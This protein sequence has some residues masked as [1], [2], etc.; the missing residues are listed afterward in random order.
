MDAVSKVSFME[1]Q[2]IWRLTTSGMLRLVD[3]QIFTDVSKERSANQ[4]ALLDQEAE[5]MRQLVYVMET[6][7][8]SCA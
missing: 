8:F 6:K 1:L 5:G 3:W 7:N 4:A 2:N